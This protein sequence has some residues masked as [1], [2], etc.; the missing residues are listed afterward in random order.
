MTAPR[1]PSI[2]GE[3]DRALD[4]VPDGEAL[5]AV[6]RAIPEA[7]R[8][9][10]DP[11]ADAQ[12]DAA[13]ARLRS[14][15]DDPTRIATRDGESEGI[16]LVRETRAAPSPGA[17]R[18]ETED[19]ASAGARASSAP[20]AG[21]PPAP[22]RA[23]VGRGAR[24]ASALRGRLRSRWVAAAALLLLVGA[25]G[26]A[27]RARPEQ[28]SV[29]AGAGPRHFLLADG[30]RLVLAPGSSARLARGF[31]G[32]L[33]AAAPVRSVRLEGEGFF[34][35]ARDGR[36]FIVETEDATVRVLGTRFDVRAS[37]GDGGTRVL[38]ESGRVSVA[39]RH[40]AAA[41]LELGA[42]DGTVV[43]GDSPLRVMAL[44]VTRLTSWRTGGLAALDEPLGAVLAE[45]QRR[46]GVRITLEGEVATAAQVSLF[47]PSVPAVESVLADLCT[48]RGLTYR[49]TSD[50]Y[51]I[52]AGPARP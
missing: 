48:M 35:V 7:P 28:L 8:T 4:A 15:L 20:R 1:D 36:P 37:P 50:G 14:R 19:G 12:R 3:L 39:R 17:V 32:L 33:G 34:T 38:V 46:F 31:R 11:A 2:P 30:S 23:P 18:A 44:P 25:G 47:Y 13:W 27:W 26:A 45:L 21:A 10:A 5:R 41:A 49:R 6:W 43:Q 29:A 40:A 24:A 9:A 22:R 42:G 51:V 52:A 16:R